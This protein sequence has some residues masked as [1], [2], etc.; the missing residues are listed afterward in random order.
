MCELTNQR[1]F[2]EEGLKETGAKRELQ[3]EG[4]IQ[5]SAAVPDMVRTIM[6]V[7][8]TKACKPTLV[9]TKIKMMSLKMSIICLLQN[10]RAMRSDLTFE[11]MLSVCLPSLPP[12]LLFGGEFVVLI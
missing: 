1:S 4:G 8:N 2:Q 5:Y 10:S 6:C 7:L 12:A 11:R 3:T 9:D